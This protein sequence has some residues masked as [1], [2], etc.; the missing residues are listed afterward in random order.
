MSNA[1]EPQTLDGLRSALQAMLNCIQRVS[2]PRWFLL[3]GLAYQSV[4]LGGTFGVI[5]FA[6]VMDLALPGL[7]RAILEKMGGPLQ[8]V[9]VVDSLFDQVLE[10][11]SVSGVLF[12][13]FALVLF[14]LAAGLGALSSQDH[15][16]EA[17]GNR[18]MPTLRAAWKAG[19]GFSRAGLGMWL[20]F[21]L[22]MFTATVLFVGPIHLFMGSTD[23][24]GLRFLGTLT[25]GGLIVLLMAYSFLLSILFQLSL[26]SLVRNR[27]G[28]GSAIQHAWRLV[29][30]GPRR[31]I[32]AAAVDM[33]LLLT[34]IILHV[35]LLF[36][37][38]GSAASFAGLSDQ[39]SN[40]VVLQEPSSW[41]NLP[42]YL[43]LAILYGVMGCARSGFWTR[44]YFTLGGIST[45]EQASDNR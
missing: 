17:R 5:V 18:P 37:L 33:A 29:K 15:W 34:T 24:S 14:R 4:V 39:G 36:A 31:V 12:V 13:P 7:G 30:A 44:A 28:V 21:P 2:R 10:M 3:S 19:R 11:G 41:I 45:V 8:A 38:P 1:T 20:L 42:V 35:A 25:A 40:P 32:R 27:R 16:D 9:P 23:L 22:M 6:P 26:Q 43:A